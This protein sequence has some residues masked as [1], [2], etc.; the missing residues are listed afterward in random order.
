MSSSH[1]VVPFHLLMSRMAVVPLGF[2]Q[3]P[4]VKLPAPK[5]SEVELGTVRDCLVALA[6]LRPFPNSPAWETG[7]A[8]S[9]AVLLLPETSSVVGGVVAVTASS[10]Q[11]A[12]MLPVGTVCKASTASIR[13]NRVMMD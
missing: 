3:A 13:K 8:T 12:A 2:T 10:G 4:T 5:A 9:V 7:A 11:C 1:P 6:N